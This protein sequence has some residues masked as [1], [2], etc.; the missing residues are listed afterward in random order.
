MTVAF[1][2]GGSRGIGFAIASRLAEAGWDITLVARGEGG[3]RAAGDRLATFGTAIHPVAADLGTGSGVEAATEAHLAAHA[4]RTDAVVLCA[5]TGWAA[6][7][8]SYPVEKLD[9]QVA[10]NFVGPFLTVQRLLPSLRHTAAAHQDARGT[11]IVVLASIAG[12]AA[13][14]GLAPYSATK[15][16]LISLCDSISSSEWEHGVTATAVS[17][18]FVDTDMTAWVRDRVDPASMIHAADVAEMTMA[19]LRLSRQATVRN[20]VIHRS[21]ADAWR[22]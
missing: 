3:V 12:T 7:I 10:L 1:V 19:V 13:D 11:K 6:P 14:G 16:A 21:G 20:V 4:G 9:Q 17:P 15:A 2:T 5:G 8:D 22:A 18:G